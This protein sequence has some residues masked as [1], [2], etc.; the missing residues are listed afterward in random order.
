MS[1]LASSVASFTRCASPPERVVE[2]CPRVIYPSPTSC[3]VLIFC[4]IWGIFSKNETASS[5]VRLSTSLID[6]PL[7]RT[8]S[9]SLL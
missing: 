1:R 3:N 9:V 7:K 4:S 8:S 2:G 5:T 6:L